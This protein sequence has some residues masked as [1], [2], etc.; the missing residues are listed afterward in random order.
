MFVVT[1]ASESSSLLSN[2]LR[3]NEDGF[4]IAGRA[5]VCRALV[6]FEEDESIKLVLRDDDWSSPD[7]A[8]GVNALEATAIKA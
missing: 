5:A 1:R 7:E 6:S 4:A 3:V 8:G 2:R